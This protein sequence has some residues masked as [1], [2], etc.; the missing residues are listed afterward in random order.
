[1]Q[2]GSFSLS[3]VKLSL[4]PAESKEFNHVWGRGTA[5]TED[6]EKGV[7]GVTIMPSSDRMVE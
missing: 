4:C 1:M 7:R 5:Y 3:S 6:G 2:G